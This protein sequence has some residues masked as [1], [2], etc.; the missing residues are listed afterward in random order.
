[1]FVKVNKEI[2]LRT[3]SFGRLEDL[4]TRLL[5]VRLKLDVERCHDGEENGLLEDREQTGRR[6]G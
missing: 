4:K 6:Y 1:M 5:R 2:G 3:S